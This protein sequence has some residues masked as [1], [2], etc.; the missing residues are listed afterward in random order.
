MC[1]S[2]LE[3]IKNDKFDFGIKDQITA[4]MFDGEDI[5]AF[6]RLTDADDVLQIKDTSLLQ[7]MPD[8]TCAQ[9][10]DKDEYSQWAAWVKI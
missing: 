3:I 10:D 5:L 9:E 4:N 6:D 7:D 2:I 8:L 1:S